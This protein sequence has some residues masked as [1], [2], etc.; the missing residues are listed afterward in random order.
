[1]IVWRHCEFV[2]RLTE[3]SKLY[4]DCKIEIITEEF[5]SKTCGNCDISK[6]I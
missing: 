5:T 3:V 2:D 6:K 1:M 4:S